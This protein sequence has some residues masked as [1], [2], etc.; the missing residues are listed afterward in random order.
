MVPVN[1]RL[2]TYSATRVW[3][4]R[5]GLEPAVSWMW[6]SESHLHSRWPRAYG[7]A[8]SLR[9]RTGALCQGV[10]TTLLYLDRSSS[11]RIDCRRVRSIVSMNPAGRVTVPADVRRTLGLGQEAFFEVEVQKG[12][13]VLRPVVVVPLEQA[14]AYTP[15]QRRGPDRLTLPRLGRLRR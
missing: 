8:R 2:P 14:K 12:A 10:K 5:H 9:T 15:D 1:G 11:R 13:L 3:F 6:G 4:P 7:P